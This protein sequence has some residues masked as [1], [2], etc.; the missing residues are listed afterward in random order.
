MM[1]DNKTDLKN[2]KSHLIILTKD[3]M[4][5]DNNKNKKSNNKSYTLL[6]LKE[7]D[8][9]LRISLSNSYK[10]DIEKIAKTLTN[11]KQNLINDENEYDN[12]IK[13]EK[14]LKGKKDSKELSNLDLLNFKDIIIFNKKNIK[15]NE[16]ES[17]KTA[18]Q[19]NRAIISKT[20]SE[21]DKYNN[22]DKKN[23]MIFKNKT[24][25]KDK[26]NIND[27][28]EIID[29]NNVKHDIISQKKL[30]KYEKKLN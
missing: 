23:Q 5:L 19:S 26:F 30:K 29:N 17:G 6:T 14:Y 4:N 24:K 8:L 10:V 28:E 3:G 16:K 21:I 22:S 18:K 25:N 9:A 7:D 27:G 2:K 13:K 11:I 20:N 12:Y 1:Y 15:L